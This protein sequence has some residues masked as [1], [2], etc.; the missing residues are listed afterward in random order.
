[1]IFVCV[2]RR[3]RSLRWNFTLCFLLLSLLQLNRISIISLVKNIKYTATGIDHFSTASTF[4]S[5]GEIWKQSDKITEEDRWYTR[6][7]LTLILLTWRMGW[8]LINASKWQMGF[9]LAFKGLSH[10]TKIQNF[11]SRVYVLYVNKKDWLP[12]MSYF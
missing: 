4:L 9:N 2:I 10:F 5:F 12:I 6:G 7:V 11:A 3:L 8:A 1:M